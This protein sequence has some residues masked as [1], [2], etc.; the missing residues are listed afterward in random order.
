MANGSSNAKALRRPWE[1]RRAHTPKRSLSILGDIDRYL[2]TELTSIIPATTKTKTDH[3][4]LS[5]DHMSHH[6]REAA[7]K[8]VFKPRIFMPSVAACAAQHVT[9]KAEHCPNYT[10]MQEVHQNKKSLGFVKADGSFPGT[11][12]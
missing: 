8:H 5:I 3:R 12:E 4:N 7:L 1:R 11:V 6:G 9:P 10:P 2:L